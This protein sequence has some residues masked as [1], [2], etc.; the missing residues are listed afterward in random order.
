MSIKRLLIAVALLALLGAGAAY[1]WRAMQGNRLPAGF[2]SG[3]GRIEANEIDIATKYA[4]RVLTIPVQEGDLVEAGAVIATLDTRDLEAQL[5]SAEAQLR[6]TR[7]SREEANALVAQRVSEADFAAKEMERALI[8][9]GK[10]HVAEQRV[11]Q[12]RNSRRTADAALEAAKSHLASAEEAI[13]AAAGDV[14]RLT[15]LVADGV[16]K[17]P[18]KSRVLYRLSEPGEVL[19][20]GGKAATLLDLSNVYMTFFLPTDMAGNLALGAEARILLDAVPDTAIPAAVTFV[21][22]RA[23]FTPKQVETKSE[24]DRMMFRVKARVPEALV[25]RYVE[26]VKTGLT[27]MAYVKLDDKAV[28]PDW[29]ES[30]LT[31]E[32]TSS[33]GNTPSPPRGE[34]RG[35]GDAPRDFARMPPSPAPGE[36]RGPPQSG[37][38]GEGLGTAPRGSG[39]C[40][41]GCLEHPSPSPPSAGP[42]PLPGR[43]RA[44]S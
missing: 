8:L 3:N 37:G 27:G 13:A 24:R 5:R 15:D 29:L 18:R 21:A 14:D 20:A 35:E 36:G 38:K 43:E 41:S 6:Q 25:T 16:L 12:A 30:K 17:A 1:G 7:S 28:W 10:G 40:G 9:F 34:G 11:D 4:A 39:P 23:Q 2:A 44:L 31:R 22:P 33:P 32:T 26:R 19:A 42:L